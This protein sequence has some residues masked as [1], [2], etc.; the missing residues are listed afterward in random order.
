MAKRT[1]SGINVIS[2]TRI[3]NAIYLIRGE[4]V[5]LDEDLAVLYQVETRALVQAVSR[6]LA[7]F[8]ED[9]AFRLSWREFTNLKSQT[10]ISS[11]GGRRSPPYAFS[12]QG[13]AML[14]S[15]L[16]SKKAVQVNIQIMR[17]FVHLRELILRHRD[18]ARRLDDLEKRTTRHDREIR[19]VFLAIR[20]LIEAP[21]PPKR[22]I[23][24]L[25]SNS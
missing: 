15:V 8:P 23:G 21:A 13:V 3:E 4:K 5:M 17:A 7:R 24:F 9:F 1:T 16:R 11:W 12:E 22:R 10:V 20:Q 18:I 2:T 25:R 19:A 6:N 14:S